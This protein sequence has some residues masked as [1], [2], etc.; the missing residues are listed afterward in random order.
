MKEI[1]T[2]ALFSLF[3]LAL[4]SLVTVSG[5]AYA[6]DSVTYEMIGIV[7]ALPGKGRSQNEVL[8]KHEPVPDYRDSSGKVVGMSAMTMPF[9][10]KEGVSLDGIQVGDRVAFRMTAVWEP[11]FIEEVV[12]IR[13]AEAKAN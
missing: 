9:Y 5:G 4:S 13:K 7:K 12:E 8:I 2:T 1:Y 10:L 11:R 3:L 6:A